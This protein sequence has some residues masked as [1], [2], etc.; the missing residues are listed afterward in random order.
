MSENEIQLRVGEIPSN[1]QSDIGVGI[2]RLDVKILHELGLREGD[3]VEI[4]G[5]R[6]TGAIAL[7][8]YPNDVGL[9]VVRMDGYMRR[10]SGTSIGEKITIKPLEL[11]EAKKVTVAPAEK[12]I[13]VQV[14]GEQ[15]K[16]ALM[17]RIVAKGDIVVPATRR[18]EAFGDFFGIDF[19]ELFGGF[20]FGETRFIIAGTAPKEICKITDLTEFIVKPKAVDI[21]EDQ[22]MSTGITYEDIGGLHEEVKKVREMIELPLKHPELFSRLGID[23]P[24]GVL[25]HGT[26]GTGK[27]LIAKA[28][29]NES[30]ASFYSIAGPE[31]MSKWYGQSEEN[32]RNIFKEAQE[33]AP[34][35]IFIDEIDALAPKRENVTGEVERRVVAQLL[36]VMDG[37]QARGDVIVIA[38]TNIPNSIDPALRRP[39]RFDREIEINVPSRRGRKEILQIHMRGMPLGKDVDVDGLA[40]ITHGFVGADLSALAREAAM[41]SLR[42]ILPDINLKDEK[43]P[44]EVLEKLEVTNKDFKNALLVVEPSAMREVLVEIPKLNWDD[45]GGLDEAK[46]YLKEMVEWPLKHPD[47]F[48][49]MG[50]TPPKG[51]LLYGLPGTGK[52]LLARAVANES[53]SNFIAITGSEV[54]SKW[55]GES[56]KRVREVFKRARQVAPSIVFI[57]E[58]DAV[59]P[60]R[61]HSHDSGSADRV[62]NQILSEL[63]GLTGLS[64]VVVIAATN[65]PD[66][67]D[68]SL[69]RPGRFDR[70]LYVPVPDKKT[71]KKIFEIYT[72]DMPL[73][74]GVN[75]DNLVSKT[76]NY[77]GADIESVCRE[78]AINALRKDI[79]SK[80]VTKKDFE[81]SLERVKP[82]IRGNDVEEYKKRVSTTK[83]LSVSNDIDYV[84]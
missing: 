28:V 58:I 82:S 6:K 83:E 79:K 56:E 72:K 84:G 81:N 33:N 19:D 64:G 63:D 5:K 11:K 8:A 30:G 51:I 66:I 67:I 26:P 77:V 37:L 42:R 12:G 41:S 65:R 25:L 43:I 10:N 70:H 57:D 39:G 61:G 53:K 45:I 52:T 21:K 27:T 3:A 40:E 44:R 47:A 38:A 46:Q 34:S 54:F 60:K 62:V 59:A 78:A 18:K 68:P 76:E 36:A 32:L 24:K 75:I 9:N 71:R 49:R 48:K 15:V 17:G 14:P 1:A 13:M 74:K 50:I 2:V 20:G 31:V 23:P 16:R 4:E 22:L 69:L 7:R 29:A 55:V 35:I 80:K 73:D